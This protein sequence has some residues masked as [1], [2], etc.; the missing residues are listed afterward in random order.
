MDPQNRGFVV[1]CNKTYLFGDEPDLSQR[2]WDPLLFKEQIIQTSV[3]HLKHHTELSQVI[4]LLVELHN[5]CEVWIQPTN[6]L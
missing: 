4:E 2:Q 5:V 1:E 6:A 3:Q